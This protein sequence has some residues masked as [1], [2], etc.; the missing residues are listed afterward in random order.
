MKVWVTKYVLTRGVFT[1][2]AHFPVPEHLSMVKTT[3]GAIYHKPFWHES[4]S[5]ARAHVMDICARKMTSLRK[6]QAL[7]DKLLTE[8]IEAVERDLKASRT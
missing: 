3:G 2:E 1:T 5:K 8:T 4:E 7:V 6:Q